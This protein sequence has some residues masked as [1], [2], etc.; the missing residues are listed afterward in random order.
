MVC[1]GL[2]PA[3]AP[4]HMFSRAH[5]ARVINHFAGVQG[6]MAYSAGYAGQTYSPGYTSG[7]VSLPLLFGLAR[8][9]TSPEPSIHNSR[10]VA[11][12]HKTC[13]LRHAIAHLHSCRLVVGTRTHISRDPPP[14]PPLC[15]TVSN[16]SLSQ[17]AHA[18]LA[19]PVWSRKGLWGLGCMLACVLMDMQAHARA[20]GSRRGSRAVHSRIPT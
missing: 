13:V 19:L 11:L 2:S 16:I 15:P 20:S 6:Q 18:V 14:A 4:C 10:T 9:C 7:V 1:L 8:C 3:G 17:P 5:Y 12:A